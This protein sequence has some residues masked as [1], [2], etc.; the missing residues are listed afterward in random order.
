MTNSSVFDNDNEW[1]D[2]V[3]P[4]AGAQIVHRAHQAAPPVYVDP[5]DPSQWRDYRAP[6]LHNAPP[7]IEMLADLIARVEQLSGAVE[8]LSGLEEKLN[9]LGLQHASVVA[10]LAAI[11]AATPPQGSGMAANRKFVHP[12]ALMHKRA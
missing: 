6:R 7:A 9:T 11:K 2:Y 10:E 8:H 5:N 3:K 1:R 12:G 4:K